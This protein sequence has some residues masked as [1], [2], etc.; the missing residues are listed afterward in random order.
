MTTAGRFFGPERVAQTL[1]DSVAPSR[2]VKST[3]LRM[4]NPSCGQS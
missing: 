1:P 4:P 3:G 2:A